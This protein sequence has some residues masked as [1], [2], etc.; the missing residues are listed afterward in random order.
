MN[1]MNAICFHCRY[2]GVGLRGSRCPQCGYPL[3]MNMGAT[4]LGATDLQQLQH[5]FE[6][7]PARP[8]PLPGVSPEPR[9][10]QL[11]IEKRRARWRVV[12][13]EKAQREAEAEKAAEARRRRRKLA[14]SFF[15]ASAL[16]A[17]L[18]AIMNVV[19]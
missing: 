19:L 13:E 17:G 2:M 8:A 12:A 16:G 4:A 14:T 6:R 15:A 7:A 11:L 1:A 5:M 9:Q 10:A 3:I 18:V